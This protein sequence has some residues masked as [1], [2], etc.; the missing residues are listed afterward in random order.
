MSLLIE[1]PTVRDD[2]QDPTNAQSSIASHGYIPIS[3][4]YI[5]IVEAYVALRNSATR[6]IRFLQPSLIAQARTA[7]PIVN[8]DL[9]DLVRLLNIPLQRSLPRSIRT[10]KRHAALSSSQVSQYSHRR[11]SKFILIHLQT[12]NT[13][14]LL[15]AESREPSPESSP[16]LPS[17][18]PMPHGPPKGE[19]ALISTGSTF[20]DLFD[21]E[22]SGCHI[23]KG[24]TIYRSTFLMTSV[25]Q[26]LSKEEDD[27]IAGDREF[28]QRLYDI[29][30]VNILNW[31]LTHDDP[32]ADFWDL[33]VP[34]LD[35]RIIVLGTSADKT[36]VYEGQFEMSQYQIISRLL[37]D[38][39]DE[40]VYGTRIADAY[41][42]IDGGSYL[43][44]GT[45]RK[46]YS[47]NKMSYPL[48]TVWNGVKVLHVTGGYDLLSFGKDYVIE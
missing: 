35:D 34:L 28:L 45:D 40:I 37:V 23:T 26:T 48:P 19:I 29:L 6:S 41:R 8:K 33:P 21:K 7:L 10:Y 1:S 32:D 43:F 22:R 3:S 12:F 30:D 27:Y 5:S 44:F 46:V 24:T 9:T 36:E 38:G 15:E 20:K 4:T 13:D 39:S 31:E 25:S 2:F 17:P 18:T 42:F 16:C 11:I 47:L 14:M